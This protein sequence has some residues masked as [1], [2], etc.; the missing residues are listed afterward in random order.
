V[1]K[2][3]GETRDLNA[4][5]QVQIDVPENGDVAIEVEYPAS[6]VREETFELFYDYDKPTAPGFSSSPPSPKYQSYLANNPA[7]PDARFSGS[8]AP[9]SADVNPS[10]EGADALRDWVRT[11]LADPPTV[12]I[13][14]HASFENDRTETKPANNLAL[15][16]RR[17]DVATGIIANDATVTGGQPHGQQEAEAAGRVG[18][19][20]AG[21]L[22]DPGTV[23]RVARITGNVPGD[24][25]RVI[26]RGRL[27][28][29][30]RGTIPPPPP[31]VDPTVDPVDPPVAPVAPSV[32]PGVVP[33][34]FCAPGRTQAGHRGV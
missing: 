1:V 24:E 8:R 10:L 6:A 34:P 16:G 23:D 9:A 19:P 11:R 2:V 13:E 4:T 26:L 27:T 28:R 17:R 25:P 22:A 20:A 7:P 33:A 30:A 12:R 3:D 29:G 14:A 18:Q 21:P 5:R 31:P 15:S 32:D